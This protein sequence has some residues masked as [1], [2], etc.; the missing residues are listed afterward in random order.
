MKVSSVSYLN[1]NFTFKSTRKSL[2]NENVS[3]KTQEKPNYIKK[4]LKALGIVGIAYMGL[5]ALYKQG[6]NVKNNSI[7][8]IEKVLNGRRDKAAVDIYKKYVAQQKMSAL[9]KRLQ[10]KEFSSV[11]K[12]I[13]SHIEKNMFTYAKISGKIPN[14]I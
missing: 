2:K 9:E 13:R 10:N 6:G 11:P 4:G 12:D 8:P 7:E 3:T 5:Y 14:I 1:N